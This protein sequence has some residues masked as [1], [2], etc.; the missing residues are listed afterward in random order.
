MP[1][2][3][4]KQHRALYLRLGQSHTVEVMHGSADTRSRPRC[5]LTS[6]T[7]LVIRRPTCSEQSSV[8]S[9]VQTVVDEIY[10][11]IWAA[12]P[13]HIDEEDWN[14]AWIAILEESVVGM[15]L[16]NHEWISDLWVLRPARGEGIGR[17]LL[18]RGE[19]EIANRGHLTFRLRVV[20]SNTSAV[21]F[22]Q[23]NGWQ[24]DREFHHE[25]LPVTM[26]EMIKHDPANDSVV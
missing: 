24:V 13:L 26:I 21:R 3:D 2:W 7:A 18:E 11:N 15:V 22:Y 5:I 25:K 9:V 4:R 20:K 23:R 14:R 16:T 6:M 8:R 10:G 19:T 1:V 12:P 17:R